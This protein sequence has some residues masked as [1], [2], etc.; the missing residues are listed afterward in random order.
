MYNGKCVLVLSLIATQ[1]E[2][3]IQSISVI[4]TDHSKPAVFVRYIGFLFICKA[5]VS[6]LFYVFHVYLFVKGGLYKKEIT[7]NCT[8]K[9]F[10]NYL[11]LLCFPG[12][13]LFL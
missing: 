9:F 5:I 2:N 1:D 11:W 4:C 7:P 3:T 6:F 8:A 13:V 12:C 10:V